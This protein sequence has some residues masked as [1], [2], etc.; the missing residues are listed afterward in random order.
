[1]ESLTNKD[2]NGCHIDHSVQ[3]KLYDESREGWEGH[4]QAVHQIRDDKV[5]E[6][7]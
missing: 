6:L 5:P 7:K 3:K 1:M 2:I 4:V